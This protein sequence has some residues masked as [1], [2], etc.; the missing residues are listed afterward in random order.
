MVED[1]AWMDSLYVGLLSDE[2]R[3][4]FEK[5]VE[6]GVAMRW[7]EGVGGFMG[8]AKV[9]LRKKTEVEIE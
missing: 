2:E 7:Y 9:K 6:Q 5:A 3:A 1:I 4:L 8:M